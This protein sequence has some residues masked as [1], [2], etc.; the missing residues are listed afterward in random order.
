[1]ADREECAGYGLGR[2]W[3]AKKVAAKRRSVNATSAVL[4]PILG[5]TVECGLKILGATFSQEKG[6]RKYPHPAGGR[7]GDFF[8]E[9]RFEN[10]ESKKD[11]EAPLP[12]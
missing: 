12:M 9:L 2:K 8:R 6:G 1:M 10:R 11:R 3:R 5:Y 4:L 7:K